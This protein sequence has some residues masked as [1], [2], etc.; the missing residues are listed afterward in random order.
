MTFKVIAGIPR[1]DGPQLLL[2]QAEFDTEGAAHLA[3]EWI[4]KLGY[5]VDIIKDDP[6]DDDDDVEE[7]ELPAEPV[8]GAA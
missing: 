4:E 7:K 5:H 2:W 6:D 1:R 8:E 3:A